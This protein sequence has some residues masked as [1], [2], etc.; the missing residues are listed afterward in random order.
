MNQPALKPPARLLGLL[1]ARAP[2]EGMSLLLAWPWLARAP[3]GDGRPVLLAP[4]YGASDR[5]MQPLFSYLG[6]LGYDM[7]HW[8]QGVNRG[9]VRR[10]VDA[11]MERVEELQQQRDGQKVT[12]IG[13]SLGGVVA[14]ELAREAPQLVREVIT[15]GTP[16]VGGPKYTSIG[17]F[18]AKLENIDMDRFEQEV[19][20]RNLRGIECPITAI[21]SKTD[22]V[23]AWRAAMDTYN[24]HAKNVQVS[25]SHLGLGVNPSVWKIIA[26]T[27]AGQYGRVAA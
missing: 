16:I 1:E 2:L 24:A 20:E 17:S 10:Y 12:L 11:L 4:G 9:N 8:G 27:L 6:W 23:V 3:R 7:H 21:Y 19:H 26:E 18:Y 14:R 13:W 15:M 22:G 25:A 5:S